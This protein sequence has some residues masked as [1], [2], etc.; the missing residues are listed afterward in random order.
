MLV[1]FAMSSTLQAQ[2][3]FPDL[4]RIPAGQSRWEGKGGKPEPAARGE[5]AKKLAKEAEAAKVVAR[6]DW[7]VGLRTQPVLHGTLPVGPEFKML[8]PGKTPLAL[9]FPIPGYDPIPAQV[10]VVTRSA[11]GKP[12]VVELIARAPQDVLMKRGVSMRLDVIAGE[13]DLGAKPLTSDAMRHIQSTDAAPYLTTEDVYGN[14]YRFDLRVQ[15]QGFGVLT[16]ELQKSGPACR[17]WKIA[18][19]LK[20]QGGGTDAA[21]PHMMGVHAYWTQWS[22]SDHVSLDLRIHNGVTNGSRKATDES[23]AVGTVYWKSLELHLPPGWKSR[24][25]VRDPFLGKATSE[26]KGWV[27]YAIVAPLPEG[28]LH[29]MGPQAQMIRRM[30]LEGPKAE[31]CEGGSAFVEGLMFCLPDRGLWSWFSLPAY[32][33][34]NTLLPRFDAVRSDGAEGRRAIRLRLRARLH[35][36]RA[37]L[38][39]QE[40]DGYK[41]VAGAMGWCQPLGQPHQGMTGGDGIFLVEGVHTAWSASREGYHA[42]QLM[43]R[44]TVC[45]QPEAQWTPEGDPVGVHGWR[46]SNGVVPFDFRTNGYMAPPEFQYVCRGGP[47]ASEQVLEVQRRE[48]RPPYDRGNP[49]MENGVLPRGRNALLS[50]TPHDGQHWIRHTKNIKTQVWLGNDPLARDGLMHQ[51]SLFRLMFNEGPHKPAHWSKGVTLKAYRTRVEEYPGHGISVDRDEAWGIDVSAAAYQIA[52]DEWRKDSLVWFRA[53]IDLF[54]LAA[55]PNGI[56]HRVH[57]IKVVGGRYDG[58][59]SFQLMFLLHALRCMNESVFQGVDPDRFDIAAD[60]HQRALDYL[61]WG[62][63][64]LGPTEKDPGHARG[65][66]NQFAAAPS[67]MIATVPYSNV[68]KWGPDYMPKDGLTGGVDMTYLYNP[69]DYA[70]TLSHE[71]GQDPSLN[72]YLKRALWLGSK[73]GTFKALKREYQ[74]NVNHSY[75]DNSRNTASFAAR[76]QAL[77]IW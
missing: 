62:P 59:Q 30:T 13:F 70:F 20:P 11:T 25:A 29:M 18:G 24:F 56:F 71:E 49:H 3:R 14:T 35:K 34:Q 15:G 53:V 55:M 50:W 42:L 33:S 52:S 31:A 72:R 46:D 16:Q 37:A 17:Q 19:V 68:K 63:A 23:A 58:C 6:M 67:G 51:A 2:D 26:G 45:R 65:P 7:Q 44:M 61:Y 4:K 36:L 43:H 32:L 76:L 64:L 39:K 27:R 54:E 28:K 73:P 40:L 9:R 74:A 41:F 38:H 47:A 1:G 12:R 69:L 77:G 75:R 48:L 5:L 57:Y 66:A 22:G 10:H 8:G 21:L 60:L